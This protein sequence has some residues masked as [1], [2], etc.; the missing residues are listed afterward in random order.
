MISQ[1]SGVHLDKI[2]KVNKMLKQSGGE[3]GNKNRMDILPYLRQ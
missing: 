2:W 3:N 1:K